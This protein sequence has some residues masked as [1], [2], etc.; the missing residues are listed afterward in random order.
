[1]K[2]GERAFHRVGEVLLEGRS[3]NFC[4]KMRMEEQDED[5]YLSEGGRDMC[6]DEADQI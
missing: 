6:G 3:E 2:D 5:S 4:L 1:M